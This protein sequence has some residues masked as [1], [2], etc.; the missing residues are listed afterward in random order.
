M[1][2]GDIENVL[3]FLLL[4]NYVTDVDTIVSPSFE[5]ITHLHRLISRKRKIWQSASSGLSSTVDLHSPA[6]TI[7]TDQEGRG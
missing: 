2:F 5:M 7:R 3:V 4:L 6:E 1:S